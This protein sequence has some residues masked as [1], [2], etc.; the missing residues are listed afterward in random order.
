MIR[1]LKEATMASTYNITASPL[2]APATGALLRL[3]FGTPA[4]NDVIVRDAVAALEACGELN[5]D[6]VL[7]NG[8]AS[9]PVACAIAHGVGHRFG[10]VACFDPKMSGYVVCITH[11]PAFE[12]GQ[13][14]PASEVREA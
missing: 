12:L 7:L 8:P 14:I 10:A 6:I 1:I 13:V 3:S 9:L 2:S 4:Q 11:N 5:G